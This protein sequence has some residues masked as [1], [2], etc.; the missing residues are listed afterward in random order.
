MNTNNF[1]G[2][3]SYVLAANFTTSSG[4]NSATY[5]GACLTVSTG[6]TNFIVPGTPSISGTWRFYGPT[7]SGKYSSGGLYIRV[8]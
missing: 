7:Y 4:C 3:G 2:I 8:S 1:G 6:A 5:A